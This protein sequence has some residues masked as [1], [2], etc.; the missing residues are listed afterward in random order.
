MRVIREAMWDGEE[1]NGVN[2]DFLAI[3][4]VILVK[5]LQKLPAGAQFSEKNVSLTVVTCQK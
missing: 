1:Q 4:Y 2:H 5:S 3:Y